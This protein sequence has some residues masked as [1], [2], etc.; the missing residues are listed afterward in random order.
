MA[1]QLLH[2]PDAILET[3]VHAAQVGLLSNPYGVIYLRSS[4]LPSK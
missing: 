1:L 4:K 2:H 3:D